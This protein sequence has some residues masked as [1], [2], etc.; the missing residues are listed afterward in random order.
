MS[1]DVMEEAP[2]IQAPLSG[3]PALE[4]FLRT[5]WPNLLGEW[6][7]FWG[8][9]SKKSYWA[10]EIN[11][12]LLDRLLAWAENEDLYV[13]CGLRGE[14]LGPSHRGE[15]D[16]VTAIPGVY[17]DVDFSDGT[18]RKKNLP[19]TEAEARQLIAEMGLPPTAVIHSGG[20]LQAWW[21]FREPWMLDSEEERVKA[22]RLTKGWCSTLRAK[23][24]AHGWDADQVGDLPRVMRLPGTWNYKTATRRPAVLLSCS[25]E[26]R[27]N[28]D[29]VEMYLQA[30]LGEQR[31]PEPQTW[32]FTL[33]PQAEPPADKFRLL[34]EVDMSFKRSWDRTRSDLQD[35]SGSAYDLSL[36][37]RA[38]SANWAPQ[39]IVNLLIASRRKHGDDLKLRKDYYERT[40][41]KAQTMP[42]HESN[43]QW[44]NQLKAGASVNAGFEVAAQ[45]NGHTAAAGSTPLQFHRTDR[46]NAAYFAARYANA[47]RY[48]HRR[49]RWLLWRKHRWCPDVDAEVHRLA[50]ASVQD[51]LMAAATCSSL[52]D[53]KETVKWAFQSE[54]RA[55]LDALLALAQSEQPIADPGDSWDLEPMLLCAPNGVIDLRT[56]ALRVGHQADRL[57]MSTDVPFDA[58]ATCPR[59]EQFM[60]EIFNADEGLVR[61]VQRAIGYSLTGDTTE[62]CLFLL[63]GSGAN[64][65]STLVNTLKQVL[66]DYAWNMPFSTIEMHQRASIPN[67]LAALVGRRFV[68]ASETND[69]TRL[70]ESRLKALTGCDLVSA[71]FLHQ[72]F[73]EFGPVAKLWLSVN[74]KPVVRDDSH[75]FWRRIRLIPFLQ[76]FP[77]DKMLGR[78]LM[79]EGPGILSWAVRGCLEWQRLGSLNPP[80]IVTEATTA[81]ERESDPLAQF[82]EDACK[83]DPTAETGA[84]ALFNAYRQWAIKQG[85][86]HEEWLSGTALGR[87]IKTRFET[88]RTRSGI[89]YL[90]VKPF[91]V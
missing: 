28:P 74:H 46:G 89:V 87:K 29:D 45:M 88:R 23:A 2:A 34:L 53:K 6:I 84:D 39:E 81:Y 49:H 58:D 63:Y 67:D 43:K 18:H 80:N 31:T 90:G 15:R 48:D 85:L 12:A 61:F 70:N 24:K 47:I 32:E 20:G 73:F 10:D 62:Q 82:L 16:T 51:R 40:L 52:E 59:W 72:E 50:T 56:G 54:S 7:L 37:T 42:G 14:N 30:D 65:K 36:A 11:D 8:A 35:Q 38:L 21:C 13:G 76:Q 86:N 41:A 64:G 79:A 27:C 26:L 5:L 4:Q 55:R 19:P 17:L 3:R 25:E 68:I 77:G 83:V 69:G 75:G 57:T 66:G 22:E 71:R 91:A 33:K 44:I 78:A 60:V 9:P 1:G